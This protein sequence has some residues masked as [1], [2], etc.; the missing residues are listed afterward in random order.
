MK[1]KWLITVACVAAAFFACNRENEHELTMPH[2]QTLPPNPTAHT[3]GVETGMGPGGF[4]VLLPPHIPV[5]EGQI[6]TAELPELSQ[7]EWSKPGT[8]SAD[9]GTNFYLPGIPDS[10]QPGSTD[11]FWQELQAPMRKPL[12]LCVQ[13]PASSCR[14]LIKQRLQA[15]QDEAMRSCETL[16]SYLRC[17]AN[18]REYTF[19]LVAQPGI[20][21]PQQPLKASN[22]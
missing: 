4:A 5:P 11:P 17:I 19:I 2:P 18:S 12:Q 14:K 7:K 20:V 10:L 8:L 9:S 21:C 15:L 1:P 6:Y 16:V 13:C 22:G 3:A